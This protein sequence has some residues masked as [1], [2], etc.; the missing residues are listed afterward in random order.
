M[1]KI[2]YLLFSQ[3]VKKPPLQVGFQG[4]LFSC[5]RVFAQMW[6][7][8]LEP[9]SS[10]SSYPDTLLAMM[11]MLEQRMWCWTGQ[12]DG[13]PRPH[14]RCFHGDFEETHV[15]VSCWTSQ[16]IRV[17]PVTSQTCDLLCRVPRRVLAA[18]LHILIHH[19]TQTAS[20]PLPPH[21]NSRECHRRRV[22]PTQ[23]VM[24]QKLCNSCYTLLHSFASL[25]FPPALS[26]ISFSKGEQ[27]EHY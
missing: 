23:H 17:S 22:T 2:Y 8:V 26:Q 7:L 3:C 12:T 18:L 13:V 10:P 1:P 19:S 11:T 4:E 14:P 9:Q 24:T 16:T 15:R 5:H 6:H 27:T 20:C 21:S 25:A